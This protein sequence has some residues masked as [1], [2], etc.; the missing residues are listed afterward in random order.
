MKKKCKD[1]KTTLTIVG[2]YPPLEWCNKCSE[3]KN[4]AHAKREFGKGNLTTTED[5]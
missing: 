4:L 2:E 5:Q 1:C 3:Y